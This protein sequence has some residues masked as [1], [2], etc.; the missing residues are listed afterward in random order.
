[1]KER[2]IQQL[3]V[4]MPLDTSADHARGSFTQ[5]D[6]LQCIRQQFRS[7]ASAAVPPGER[8]DRAF[9]GLRVLNEQL[10]M[11]ER[12]SSA[13]TTH[14]PGVAV[15]VEVT[16]AYAGMDATYEPDEGVPQKQY[17]AYRIRIS[18]IGQETV[19]LLG[20]HWQILNEEGEMVVE[21][22]RG[23]RGVVGC[24][25]RLKP[26]TCFSY[27]SGTDLEARRGSMRGSFQMVVL[28]SQQ[29]PIRAFDAEVA[30]FQFRA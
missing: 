1:M 30:P 22:P 23:S 8:L 15:N 10:A 26:G 13:T 18:N 12:S 19:Q 27:Y 9:E 24:T 17:F 3:D 4:R 7:P 16:T 25:P 11:A 6:L 2:G 29:R 20:R 14:D 5:E 21:V 28:D